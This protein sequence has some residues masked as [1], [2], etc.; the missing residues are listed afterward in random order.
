[1]TC[2]RHLNKGRW[3]GT[4]VFLCRVNT[5]WARKKCCASQNQDVFTLQSVGAWKQTSA[6]KNEG[7]KSEDREEKENWFELLLVLAPTLFKGV[8]WTITY[9]WYMCWCSWKGKRVGWN[10]QIVD[11]DWALK[12]FSPPAV[13][14]L[15]LASVL[16]LWP[17]L[18]RVQSITYMRQGQRQ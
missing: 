1:M 12:A 16:L 10:Y 9:F 5:I 18:A 2:S 7:C 4:G 11:H 8:G 13:E 6:E 17:A 15:F 14:L 3:M